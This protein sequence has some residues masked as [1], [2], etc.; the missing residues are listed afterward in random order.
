MAACLWLT[1]RNLFGEVA[2]LAAVICFATSPLVPYFSR[3]TQPDITAASLATAAMAV[4]AASRGWTTTA[5]AFALAAASALV[6]LP[7]AVYFLPVFCFSTFPRQGSRVRFLGHVVMAGLAVAVALS[8][9]QYARRLQLLHGLTTFGLTR[10][11][12]QLFKEW[13]MPEFW[14][15]P[16]L[17]YPFDVWVFPGCTVLLLGVLLWRRRQIPW[18]V[19]ILGLTVLACIFL[20]GYSAAVHEYYGVILLPGL[21]LMVGWCAS[22]LLGRSSQFAR[23]ALSVLVV[24]AIGWQIVRSRSF[25]SHHQAEWA[26]LSAFSRKNLGPQGSTRIAVFT[27]GSP[28]MFWFTGQIGRFGDTDHPEIDPRDGF[29]VVDRVRLKDRALAVE[30]VLRAQGCETVFQ[31]A[32]GWVC[33]AHLRANGQP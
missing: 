11:P 33:Q 19:G 16:F 9:Y 22:E 14:L 15:R 4:A 10:S 30:S 20:C 13:T 24:M 29:G 6:K 23:L 17:Q 3:T 2:A 31:N 21:T 8:W 12:S 27:D 26:E 25:W 7:T 28:E 18:P 1:G 32:V 5:L